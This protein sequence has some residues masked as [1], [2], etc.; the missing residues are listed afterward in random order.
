MNEEQ[1]E[2]LLSLLSEIRDVLKPRQEVKIVER[3]IRPEAVENLM[4]FKS[5]VISNEFWNTL[6]EKQRKALMKLD[7][8]ELK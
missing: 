6:G 8:G 1:S 7:A 3:L 5:F 2:K 4:K